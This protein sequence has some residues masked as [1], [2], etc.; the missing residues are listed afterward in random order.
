MAGRCEMNAYSDI[1]DYSSLLA[2][3]VS[4]VLAYFGKRTGH[5]GYMYYSPFRDER[6]PSM[7]VTVNSADGTWVWADYGGSPTGGRRVD[8]GGVLEMVRRLS[9]VSGDSGAVSV[10]REIAAGRGCP[11]VPDVSPPER[12][13]G[14]VIDDV[15][16]VFTSGPVRRYATRVRRIPEPLLGRYCRQVRYH[17]RSD[18]SRS[19]IAIGF[20][21]NAGGWALRGRGA[22][23]KLNSAWGL[24]TLG[25]DGSLMADGRAA[26]T[27]G[28]L[29]EGFMDF[30][31]YL[32]WRGVL[33]PGADVCV[34]HSASNIVHA[35]EWALSHGAVRSFFDNDR[36]GD[37]ATEALASWCGEAGLDFRDGRG[38][39]ASSNDLNEAWQ[40]EAASRTERPGKCRG[41]GR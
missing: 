36:A 17:P 26:S 22:G 4:D 20:P 14:I 16:A 18:P 1:P 9:G 34:L 29:F 40:A 27:R 28:L 8:G 35:R 13:T 31:S 38:A 41:A 10:L 23:A 33:E 15:S 25:P 3:P 30:L 39:Y 7:R 11:E 37:T 24:T 12:E 19:Y 32:A 21:N 2:I 6:E 5:R